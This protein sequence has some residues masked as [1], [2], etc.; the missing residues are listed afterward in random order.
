[1]PD[2][3]ATQTSLWSCLCGSGNRLSNRRASESRQYYFVD[4]FSVLTFT[5]VLLLLV[6]TLLDGI[7]TVHLLDRGCDELNPVMN[8]LLHKGLQPFFL[9]KYIL[10]AAG[11][12]VL[13][14]FKNYALFGSRFRVGYLLPAFVGLYMILL[15][16]QWFLCRL[17][18]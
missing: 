18:R 17:G 9:G 5:F 8:Y 4:R 7:V 16:Y 3:R 10:T 13:L 6:F 11:L 12:P 2:R 1:M 14:V 15:C